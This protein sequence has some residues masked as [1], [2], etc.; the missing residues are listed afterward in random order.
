VSYHRT[1][2]GHEGLRPDPART[3]VREAPDGRFSLRELPAGRWSVTVD[4]GRSGYERTVIHDVAVPGGEDLLFRV[5]RGAH[6]EGRLL[7]A[8]G[9]A[10]G[11]LEIRL[12]PV[13]SPGVRAGPA[14]LVATD[15]EGRFL[16]TRVTPGA[17]R[18]H[19]SGLPSDGAAIDVASNQR[20]E[21][22]LRLGAT[23]TLSITVLDLQGTPVEGA[24]LLLAGRSGFRSAETDAAGDSRIG[25]LAPDR[26][27]LRVS[28]DGFQ[29]QDLDLVLRRDHLVEVVLAPGG[30]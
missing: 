19:P 22:D 10:V 6:V 14:T 11:G 23:T 21:Q 2:D 12:E 20:V 16:F 4:P 1:A 5:G 9:R 15:G 30:R 3:L 7:D 27:A 13:P 17:Y 29:A 18:L 26:F 24:R 25:G 8:L 28:R